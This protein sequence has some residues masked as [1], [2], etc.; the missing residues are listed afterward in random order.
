MNTKLQWLRYLVSRTNLSIIF[1]TDILTSPKRDF[2]HN[3]HAQVKCYD[4]FPVL[5]MGVF[6]IHIPGSYY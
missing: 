5:L 6:V 1:K 3:R 2:Y 4:I